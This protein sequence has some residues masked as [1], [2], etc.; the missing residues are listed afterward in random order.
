MD[1]LNPVFVK[2]IKVDYYFEMQQIY[3]VEVYDVDDIT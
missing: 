2:E 1:N 3:K